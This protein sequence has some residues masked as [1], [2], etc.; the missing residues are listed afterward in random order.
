[1]NW[2]RGKVWN[3]KTLSQENE[4]LYWIVK[5]KLQGFKNPKKIVKKKVYA[6]F[7]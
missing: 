5:K 1:M 6:I 4:A 7:F 2:S 3:K